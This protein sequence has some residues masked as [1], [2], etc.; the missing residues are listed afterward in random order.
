MLV[1]GSPKSPRFVVADW[2]GLGEGVGLDVFDE[3]PRPGAAFKGPPDENRDGS[4]PARP[5]RV[6]IVSV[7]GNWAKSGNPSVGD[8]GIVSRSGVELPLVGGP[9]TLLLVKPPSC[10]IS[11]VLSMMPSV[12][13]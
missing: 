13:V 4:V 3:R 1:D 9:Q 2:N 12:L 8:S 10:T 6:G 5:R 11:R 7:V